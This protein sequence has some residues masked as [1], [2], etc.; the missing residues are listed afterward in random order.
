MFSVC[1]RIKSWIDRIELLRNE[2]KEESENKIGQAMS[3]KT[4]ETS[5]S[6]FNW[7]VSGIHFYPNLNYISL[8]LV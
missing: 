4:N 6:P 3:F 7:K 2:A 8:S 5:L 1:V